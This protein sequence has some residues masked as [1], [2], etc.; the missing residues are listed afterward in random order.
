M[1]NKLLLAAVIIIA[2]LSRV[3]ASDSLIYLETQ[4]VA[5]YSSL[6]EK[7]IYYSMNQNMAMQKPSVGIDLIKKYSSDYGDWGT[8][9]VQ[10]RVAYDYTYYNHLETEIF[11]AY[12]KKN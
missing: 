11:N 6:Q 7:I 3:L 4:M 5:G 2:A 1:L 8:L 10:A 12:F 9:A